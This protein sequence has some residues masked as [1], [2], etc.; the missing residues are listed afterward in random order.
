M[1]N[2][3]IDFLR[4]IG[5]FMIILAHCSP[6]L[7]IFQIRNFDVPL[8]VLISGVS[9]K[10]S[11]K[12]ND[13]YFNYVWK[14]IKRL[15]FPVWIFLTLFFIFMHFGFP[16]EITLHQIITSYLLLSGI[17]YV[18][19]IRVFLLVALI[20]PFLLKIEQKTTSNIYFFSIL[21]L[22]LL[23]YEILKINTYDYFQTNDF[24]VIVGRVL[25]YIIPYSL[26]YLLG[27]RIYKLQKKYTLY[28]FVLCLIT[29]IGMA[30][31]IFLDENKFIPTQVYKNPLTTYYLSY[32]LSISTLLWLVGDSIWQ[33]LNS[34]IKQ[35]ILFIA[36]N[37]I[38]IYLWHIPFIYIIE[39]TNYHYSLEYVF[40]LFCS[41]LITYLQ[42]SLLEKRILPNIS[43]DKIRRNIK[44]LF[45]G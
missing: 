8:M 11:F 5:L 29:F 30:S 32:A 31:I 26:I 4:F 3:K 40:V 41:I 45:K 27:I 2:F 36:S 37:S 17:G 42:V 43:N 16:G 24:L 21:V 10:L 25:F 33:K 23:A 34:K 7:V 39:I 15:V 13:S 6:H 20:A 12:K 38:W 19:I 22:S 18:W 9:F 44:T 35:F 1:R 14:R 28:I